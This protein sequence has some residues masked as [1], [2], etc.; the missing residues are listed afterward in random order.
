MIADKRYKIELID[1]DIVLVTYLDGLDADL[2]LM[3]TMKKEI[4]ELTNGKPYYSMVSM[5]DVM[6]AISEEAKEFAAK[7][8]EWT[9]LRLSEALF[10]NS[11]A[12]SVLRSIH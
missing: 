4:L 1:T 10:T 2:E 8:E 5:M 6:G 3:K 12:L 9:R 7:D 11:F